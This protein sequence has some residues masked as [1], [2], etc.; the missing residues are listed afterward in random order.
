MYIIKR[1]REFEKSFK[2]IRRAGLAKKDEIILASIIDTLASGRVLDKK[3]K[4][5]QLQGEYKNYRECHVLYDLLLMYRIEDDE[6]VLVLINIG[7]H[8][9]LFR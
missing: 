8:S 2:K 9:Q 7:S 3:Y 5:H 1:T 4:D 6:L